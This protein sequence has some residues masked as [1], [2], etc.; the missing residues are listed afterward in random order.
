MFLTSVIMGA[1]IRTMW[2]T[3]FY[4]FLGTLLIYLFQNN[5]NFND[6]KAFSYTFVF[7]FLLSPFL[8]GYISISQTDK[9][10]DFQGEENLRIFKK[11]L[12]IYNHFKDYKKIISISGNE[13]IA[14]NLCY[15][16]TPRPKCIVI[17]SA[18]RIRFSVLLKNNDIK[19]G[20]LNN[21]LFNK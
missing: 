8:Y 16:L 7:L 3:P 12:S 6:L 20:S 9:R 4:L 2:M 1:K 10:T 19:F 15:Q 14:G 18:D 17:A 21:N 5:I 13:W 11:N